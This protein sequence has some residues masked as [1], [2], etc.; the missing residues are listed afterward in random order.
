MLRSIGINCLFICKINL[1]TV[2]HFWSP[3]VYDQIPTIITSFVAIIAKISILIV[4]YELIKFTNAGHSWTI[5]LLLS[6]LLS[7]LIGSILGLTQSRIKRL[8]A[9]S[10]ISH[11]GFILLALSIYSNDSLIAF[12]FYLVQYTLSNINLFIITIIIGYSLY[13][14]GSN[15]NKLLSTESPLQLIS[16]LKGYS[17][18]NPVLALSLAITLFS[19]AG[20]SEGVECLQ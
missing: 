19:F 4:L 20:M 6:S 15:N 7:I 11:V 13:I 10:A 18:I 8:Y 5:T 2:F 17:S 9:Y 3:D 16:Q 14:S 12:L 1:T